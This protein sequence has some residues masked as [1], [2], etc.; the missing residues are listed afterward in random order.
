VYAAVSYQ[1]SRKLKGKKQKVKGKMKLTTVALSLTLL[2]LALLGQNRARG[3][4]DPFTVAVNTPTIEGGPVYGRLNNR[5][6]AVIIGVI[7]R[8]RRCR[9]G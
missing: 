3:P 2:P 1:P 4:G 5:A 9:A 7:A 8:S 6:L